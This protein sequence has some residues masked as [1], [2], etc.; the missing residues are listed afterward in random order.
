MEP[1]IEWLALQA[2]D[3]YFKLYNL[4]P[5]LSLATQDGAMLASDDVVTTL[6]SNNEEVRSHVSLM[7]CAGLEQIC[8]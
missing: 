5:V 6:L 8:V 7:H 4:R 2:A 3:R 1:T